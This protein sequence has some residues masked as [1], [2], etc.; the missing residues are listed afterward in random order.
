MDS[1]ETQCSTS[2]FELNENKGKEFRVDFSKSPGNP[3][4]V[5]VHGK[6]LESIKE[7]KLLGLTISNNLKWNTHIESIIKKA[8]KRIYFLKQLKRAKIPAKDMILFYSLTV[9]PLLAT[10]L[11]E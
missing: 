5:L 10:K 1:F 4:P 3:T 11:F 9:I 8:S 2:K 6:P 7:P